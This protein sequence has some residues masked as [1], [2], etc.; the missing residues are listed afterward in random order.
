MASELKKWRRKDISSR[1]S[2][3]EERLGGV[4]ERRRGERKAVTER[5]QSK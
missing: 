1:G 5:T 3:E 2:K 4:G